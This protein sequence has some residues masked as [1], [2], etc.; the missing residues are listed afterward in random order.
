MGEGLLAT[1]GA[2]VVESCGMGQ[3]YYADEVELAKPVVSWRMVKASDQ[4]G[5]LGMGFRTGSAL[6]MACTH[7]KM[8]LLECEH[9]QVFAEACY[10][11]VQCF[12]TEMSSGQSGD[13]YLVGFRR[14][15][16]MESRL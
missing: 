15:L 7:L 8:C 9:E 10:N 6:A 4:A 14:K 16:M 12:V 5:G 2:D 1:E 3:Q 13:G 11:L